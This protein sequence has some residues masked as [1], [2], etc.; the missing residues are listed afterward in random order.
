MTT[1][2]TSE[3][4]LHNWFMP[5]KKIKIVGVGYDFASVEHLFQ[6]LKFTYETRTKNEEEFVIK[7]LN[8][9]S[10]KKVRDYS[11]DIAYLRYIHCK[12]HP[13]WD[14][15]RRASMLL[16]VHVRLSGDLEAQKEL[17]N[18]GDTSI[19]YDDNNIIWG[20][21][22]HG[23]GANEMGSIL[24]EIRAT[25]KDQKEKGIQ[26]DSDVFTKIQLNRYS[27]FCKLE[28]KY[29]VDNDLKSQRQLKR[30]NMIAIEKAKINAMINYGDANKVTC[31]H[32]HRD[33]NRFKELPFDKIPK[34]EFVYCL[35]CKMSC[36]L[37]RDSWHIN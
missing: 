1:V 26:L 33:Y 14:G 13:L 15:I 5:E 12:I 22:I 25:Y 34:L 21:G 20:M 6:V 10:P 2:I 28:T 32:H 16:A 19:L 4:I 18:T 8:V 3:N 31:K 7:I 23:C 37:E 27:A 11:E 30:S 35:A 17:L 9:D 24:E 36:I 29:D